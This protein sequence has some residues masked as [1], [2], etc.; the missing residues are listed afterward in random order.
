MA[1]SSM[2]TLL[3]ALARIPSLSSFYLNSTIFR[4]EE[5]GGMQ[6]TLSELLAKCI[7]LEGKLALPDYSFDISIESS[8]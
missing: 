6:F 4:L 2:M 7:D 8:I 1:A 3:V 5:G